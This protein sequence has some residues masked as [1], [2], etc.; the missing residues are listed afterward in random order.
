MRGLL[1]G[2]ILAAAFLAV[3]LLLTA[4]VA[5]RP[6]AILKIG[7]PAAAPARSLADGRTVNLFTAVVGNHRRQPTTVSL[8]A[9]DR[10]G[11]SLELLGPAQSIRL[12]PGERRRVDFSAVTAPGQ[13]AGAMNLLLRD[14]TGRVLAEAST[15]L[16]APP[17][18]DGEKE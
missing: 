8:T 11:H 18:P 3:S 13:L 6:S 9:T 16:L 17:P 2:R 15:Q 10:Q 1:H 14:D 4:A 12:D 7:R 5:T